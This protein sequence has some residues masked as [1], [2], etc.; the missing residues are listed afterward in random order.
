MKYISKRIQSF[1]N[2]HEINE[3]STLLVKRSSHEKPESYQTV[4][5][6][7]EISDVKDTTKYT[8]YI[9]SIVGYN[10]KI[11]KINEKIKAI[12]RAGLESYEQAIGT[13]GTY[14][15]PIENGNFSRNDYIVLS[16][17]NRDDYNIISVSDK[18]I[19]VID[20]KTLAN[21][22]NIVQQSTD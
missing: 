7:L 4:F 8:N 9:D 5:P 17:K 19:K 1:L 22:F 6:M 21:N 10:S 14:I 2:E 12:H 16:K 11:N 15:R 3:Y 18:S 20:W 13:P